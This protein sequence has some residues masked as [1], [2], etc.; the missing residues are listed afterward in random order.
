MS[1]NIKDKNKFYQCSLAKQT[2]IDGVNFG[3]PT[4]VATMISYIP[5]RH[6]V[7]GNVLRIKR[8]DYW[9]EGWKVMVVYNDS[10]DVSF[11]VRKAIKRHEKNTG[12]SLKKEKKAPK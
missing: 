2:V 4:T 10:A 12:D 6:A 9:E 3:E 11:D 8:G 1:A 5:A 7:L